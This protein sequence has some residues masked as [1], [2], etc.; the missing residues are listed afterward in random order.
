[1]QRINIS[2][3]ILLLTIL[4]NLI[5][6]GAEKLS[7]PEE[8]SAVLDSSGANRTELEKVLSHYSNAEDSLKL[9]S[10]YFLISNME[11]HSYVTYALKDTSGKEINF[12]PL[13]YPDYNTLE[14][15]FDTLKS[16]YD[17]LDFK[18]KE[19]IFDLDTITADFLISQI[20]YAFKAWSEKP[21]AKDLSFENFREYVL[22]YR[23]SNEPLENWREVFRGK[24][25]DIQNKMT[26][27]SNPVE[28]A[29]LIND[30]VKSWFTFNPRFYYH[31]TDQGLSEML[32]NRLGRC[33][34]MTNLTIYAMRANGL[35][36]TSDY[37][38]AW[39]DFGN[40]HAWNAIVTPDGRVIP[41]MG[42]EANPG[43]YSLA[44]KPAKVYR[45]MFGKQEENLVFQKRKQEKIPGW[46]AGKNYLDVTA[47]YEDVCDVTIPFK[48][49][50]PDSVDVA[51]LCVFND[52]EWKPIHWGWIKNGEVVFTDMG[53]EIAYLPALYLNEKVVPF[54]TPFL[55]Q[56]DC[57]IRKLEPESLK[58]I[59]VKLFAVIP[60]KQEISTGGIE[61][62]YFT[63]GGK[64]E[65]FYWKDE[66]QLLGSSIASDKPLVFEKVPA[67]SL[68]W[69]VP[70]GSDKEEERIFTIEDGKQVWW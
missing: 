9:Q 50:I 2:I 22:P 42:A 10:A 14:S 17:E 57:T 56:K 26:D 55:L 5:T 36:V 8:V 4:P 30:D 11:G 41:F 45:K 64:Y 35:A 58:T 24:Y 28:A 60:P 3:L 23:G 44:H 59:S 21:W 62:T 43:E 68:Y 46:L 70:E 47:E 49:E 34:D 6:A 32:K 38:P 66:W 48:R 25:K 19:E 51:Y 16:R 12:N 53:R 33:E 15:A 18:K 63:S 39:A 1:M 27:P 7:Y 37:T 31:P 40:N 65:L 61:K 52:G 29:R 54:G 67:G 69:L 20:D 13:D